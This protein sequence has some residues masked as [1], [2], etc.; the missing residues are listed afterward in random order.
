[1]FLFLTGLEILRQLPGQSKS[2]FSH[3]EEFSYSTDRNYFCQPY[4]GF[5]PE[6]N[7]YRNVRKGIPNSLLL[8][9]HIN[10]NILSCFYI[11]PEILNTSSMYFR[12]GSAICKSCQTSW[13]FRT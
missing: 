10:P 13:S 4:I 12:N 3:I 9:V 2:K 7:E 8:K 1:M 6:S 11:L 5:V